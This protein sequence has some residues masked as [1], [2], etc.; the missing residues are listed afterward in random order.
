MS[1]L[2]STQITALIA[3][4]RAAADS[5]EA[6]L[7]PAAVNK[8]AE[9]AARKERS[10]KGKSRVKKPA[11]DEEAPEE[12]PNAAKGVKE[13]KGRKPSAWQEFV[14]ASG[15]I[16]KASEAKKA[17]PDA[18]TEFV[19]NWTAENPNPAPVKAAAKPKKAVVAVSKAKVMPLLPASD[20]EEDAP[21]QHEFINIEG[22]NYWLDPDMNMLFQDDEGEPGD[23]AYFYKDGEIVNHL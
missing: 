23:F 4:I 5:L 21:P 20:D 15:G 16:K 3:Q 6:S 1:T 8:A 14:K 17:D 2:T 7:V 13:P 18:Y 12:A 11:A 10:D 22:I 19:E 9:P